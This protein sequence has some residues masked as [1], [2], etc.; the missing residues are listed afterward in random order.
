MLLAQCGF[1]YSCRTGYGWAL[2]PR[3]EG[4]TSTS[5]VNA[6]Q[7][8]LWA[9]NT[10]GLTPVRDRAVASGCGAHLSR[11]S[12]R[13]MSFFFSR[14]PLLRLVFNW[15]GRTCRLSHSKVCAHLTLNKRTE[16][17]PRK[18]WHWCFAFSHIFQCTGSPGVLFFFCLWRCLNWFHHRS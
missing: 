10:A 5:Q 17:R 6:A 4:R 7:R 3:G 2:T 11:H 12:Q 14:Q 1:I 15:L 18:G 8:T 16:T 9:P 13:G